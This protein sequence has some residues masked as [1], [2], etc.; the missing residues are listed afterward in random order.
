VVRD[1]RIGVA[2]LPAELAQCKQ[3]ADAAE[4]THAALVRTV[5]LIGLP[6]YLEQQAAGSVAG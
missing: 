4:T 6:Q 5:Y 1:A 2:F 3:L